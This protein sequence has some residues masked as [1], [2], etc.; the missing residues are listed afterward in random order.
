MPNMHIGALC[1]HERYDGKGYPSGLKGEEIPIEARM[2]SI[3]DSYDAMSSNRAYREALPREQVL[4]ELRKGRGTQF[5]PL[6]LDVFLDMLDK[7]FF[8]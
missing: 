5:D 3:A 6:V 4:D 2:I 8:D 7:N 1:H